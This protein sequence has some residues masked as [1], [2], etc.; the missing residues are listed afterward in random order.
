MNFDKV[1]WPSSCANHTVG[2]SG[3]K[4]R[5]RILT[6]LIVKV[7]SGRCSGRVDGSASC[8][9]LRS[10]E[11]YYTYSRHYAVSYPRGHQCGGIGINYPPPHTHT[12]SYMC[13]HHYSSSYL[14]SLEPAVC[15]LFVCTLQFSL[16]LATVVSVFVM[17]GARALKYPGKWVGESV[18]PPQQ[19]W[20]ILG[21][22]HYYFQW[23][24]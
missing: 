3:R 22:C 24:I 16:L 6:R 7:E 1:N 23:A 8:C 11:E 20:C 9:M 5:T 12:Q 19:K 21:L 13:T 4:G 17:C 14:Q 2:F 18:A 15:L 10:R